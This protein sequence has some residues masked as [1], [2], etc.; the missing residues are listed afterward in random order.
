MGNKE[1]LIDEYGKIFAQNVKDNSELLVDWNKTL[2]IVFTD[3]N[4]GWLYKIAKDGTLEKMEKTPA[5]KVDEADVTVFW[6]TD[7]FK[8]MYV[9]KIQNIMSAYK[10]GLIKVEGEM[11]ALMN[12]QFL[13]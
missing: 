8:E 11:E 13:F 1:K 3:A 6:S 7:T 12:V 2:Q 10:T 9:E 4:A 5:Q